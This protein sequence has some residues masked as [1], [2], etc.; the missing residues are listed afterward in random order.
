MTIRVGNRDVVT[1][2]DILP[3]EGPMKMLMIAKTPTLDSVKAGHYFQGRQGRMLWN[4]LVAY[5]LLQVPPQSFEDEALLAHGYGLTD[6]VKAPRDYGQ[7]PSDDEYREGFQRILGLVARLEP[8]VLL[9]VY[10]RVL[11]QLLQLAFDQREKS[12]YGFN[13]D[14]NNAFTHGSSSFPCPAPPARLRRPRRL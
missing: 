10:K 11:D 9:F 4:R 3:A 13:D 1:L 6:I 12:I 5:D 14:L 8:Q 2:A 7:E